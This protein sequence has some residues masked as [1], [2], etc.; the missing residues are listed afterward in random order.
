MFK[1]SLKRAKHIWRAIAVRGDQTLD[2]LHEAIFHAFD[3]SDPHLYSFYL[4]KAPQ[5]RGSGTARPKE[6]VAELSFQESVGAERTFNFNAATTKIESLGLK[7]GQTLQYLFDY[8]DMWW[9]E[10]KVEQIGA[11]HRSGYPAI[12]ASHGQSPRQYAGS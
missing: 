8:G 5:R 3:R 4:P 7:I 11:A 6:Y 9:H 10:V 12:V 2:D 1:V